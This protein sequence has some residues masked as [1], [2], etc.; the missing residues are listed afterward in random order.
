MEDEHLPLPFS[1]LS[2]HG[3]CYADLT[4]HQSGPSMP[5]AH[6]PLPSL[7][8]GVPS[9][10]LPAP[11]FQAGPEPSHPSNAYTGEPDADSAPY[12]AGAYPQDDKEV[13]VSPRHNSPR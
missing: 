7:A 12:A 8:E 5:F 10:R 6:A 1:C 13:L 11:A 2:A 9:P 4:G 3:L